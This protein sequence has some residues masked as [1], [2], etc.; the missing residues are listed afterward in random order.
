MR[1]IERFDTKKID[2]EAVVYVEI[3]PTVT[4]E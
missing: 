4:G 3:N 2:S 1:V